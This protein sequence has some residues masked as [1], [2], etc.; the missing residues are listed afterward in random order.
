MIIDENG[1][2][3]PETVIEEVELEREEKQKR[4][5]S[6]W[7][8]KAKREGWAKPVHNQGEKTESEETASERFFRRKAEREGWIRNNH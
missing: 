8:R 2:K 6:F 7:N 1:V 3:H 4:Q 5:D